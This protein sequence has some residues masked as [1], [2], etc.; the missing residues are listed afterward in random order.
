MLPD[1]RQHAMIEAPGATDRAVY[2]TF[3]PMPISL[4]FYG[5][6]L[7][8]AGLFALEAAVAKLI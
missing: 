1:L 7:C 5:P 2:F 4:S 6:T 8:H 3:S